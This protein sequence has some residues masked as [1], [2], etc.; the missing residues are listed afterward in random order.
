[1]PAGWNHSQEKKMDA[2]MSA[3]ETG[4]PKRTEAREPRRR[5]PAHDGRPRTEVNRIRNEVPELATP[6][7]AK[8]VAVG[9]GWFSIGLGLLELFGTHQLEEWLGVDN[10]KLI[11]AYG[12]REIAAGAGILMGSRIAPFIWNRVAGDAVDIASLAAAF[13]S[14]DSNRRNL[15][16]ALGAVLGVTALDIVDGMALSST[17]S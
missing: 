10:A 13:R 9:L 17:R 2:T 5:A 6:V 4:A 7:W 15:A 1:V 14:D 12:V 11:R 16:I 3:N 8:R